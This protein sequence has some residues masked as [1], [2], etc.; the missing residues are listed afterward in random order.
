[1]LLWCNCITCGTTDLVLGVGIPLG[2]PYE[3][4]VWRRW[5]VDKYHRRQASLWCYFDLVLTELYRLQNPYRS[6]FFLKILAWQ[7]PLYVG[8]LN[9]FL[10]D[11]E[12]ILRHFRNSQILG[13]IMKISNFPP[14]FHRSLVSTAQN[15]ANINAF[16]GTVVLFTMLSFGN[17]KFQIVQNVFFL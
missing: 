10:E 7:V 6:I 4:S 13:R 3:S 8:S 11:L 17:L 2:V 1:M 5:Y 14:R 15:N 12:L 9:W 16:R